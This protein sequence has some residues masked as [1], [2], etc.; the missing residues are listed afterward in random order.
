MNVFFLEIR[1]KKILI[2]TSLIQND[3]VA[4]KYVD[5]NVIF[6]SENNIVGFNILDFDNS[7]NLKPGRIILNYQIIN[8]INKVLSIN[9]SNNQSHFLVG[10]VIECEKIDGTHLS[11]TKV[12][13]GDEQL[14]IVCGAKNVKK[15]LKVVVATI[16]VVMNDGSYIKKGNLRGYDS[17]GM[18]CSKKELGINNEH[19]NEEGIIE[20]DEQYEIGSIFYDAYSNKG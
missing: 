20:L 13:V 12:D 3:K 17:F 10:K 11:L 16:G 4:I 5:N 7:L 14:L 1:D 9:I 15:G 6:Y 19:F 18:L 2:G 8:Y